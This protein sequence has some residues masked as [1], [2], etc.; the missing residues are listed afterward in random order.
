MYRQGDV[1]LI[2][3]PVN[4]DGMKLVKPENGRLILARGE[5]TGHHHSVCCDVA[6]LFERGDE[7]ALVVCETTTLDHQEHGTIEI[8]PGTYWTVRQREYTPAAIVRVRD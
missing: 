8:A 7:M 4:M 3:R 6:E 1:L 5:A 2:K